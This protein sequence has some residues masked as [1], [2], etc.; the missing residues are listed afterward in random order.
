MKLKHDKLISNFGFNCNVRHYSGVAA[1]LNCPNGS[2]CP[3]DGWHTPSQ[4]LPKYFAG[5]GAVACVNC[6]AAG[7]PARSSTFQ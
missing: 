1:C 2:T 6:W 5:A 7:I 4:C 3:L